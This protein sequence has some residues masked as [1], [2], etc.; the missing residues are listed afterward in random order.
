MTYE[1]AREMELFMPPMK[2][3]RTKVVTYN[4]GE[5]YIVD[6]VPDV[7]SMMG[8]GMS[9]GLGIERT[10][11][12]EIRSIIDDRIRGLVDYADKDTKEPPAGRT[13]E[14]HNRIQAFNKR[15]RRR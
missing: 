9:F 4:H 13:Q 15:G 3:M 12:M 5:S 8:A 1:Q 2:H 6:Y 11:E 10:L 7:K 14:A